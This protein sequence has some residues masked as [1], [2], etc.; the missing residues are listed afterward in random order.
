METVLSEQK[1]RYTA[2][3]EAAEAKHS[4]VMKEL[5][6]YKAKFDKC[7]GLS[8]RSLQDLGSGGRSP[9]QEKLKI[10]N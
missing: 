7:R 2:A 4:G 10:V 8:Q 1:L 5:E 9:P 6:M 3:V